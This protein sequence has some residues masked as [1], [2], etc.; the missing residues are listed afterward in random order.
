LPFQDR[1]SLPED[2][3]ILIQ[4]TPSY[5]AVEDDKDEVLI[6]EEGALA[7]FRGLPS[8]CFR[9]NEA[10]RGEV[11]AIVSKDDN[12]EVLEKI[13]KLLVLFFREVQTKGLKVEL[14]C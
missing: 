7:L 8:C 13:E 12:R 3:S 11:R 1:K 10:L 5:K 4:R 6:V 9:I 14:L 2:Y